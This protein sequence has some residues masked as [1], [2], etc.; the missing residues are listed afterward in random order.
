M[1]RVLVERRLDDRRGETLAADLDLERRPFFRSGQ[2]EIGR[3]DR[4]A[5]RGTH[6]PTPHLAARRAAVEHRIAMARE[7]A[8][9]HREAD[10]AARETT[11]LLRDERVAA[12]EVALAELDEPGESRLEGSRRVVDVVAVE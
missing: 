12:D 7:A 5:Q 2:R 8:L 9:S 4:H 11:L 1:G 3:A 6:R 10:E